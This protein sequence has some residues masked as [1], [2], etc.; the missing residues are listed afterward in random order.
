VNSG[1]GVFAAIRIYDYN[2]LPFLNGCSP[3]RVFSFHDSGVIGDGPRGVNGDIVGLLM[4]G[5]G[6]INGD[7]VGRLIMGLGGMILLAS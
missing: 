5:L 3:S 6:G 4:V 2:A 1:G 7:I